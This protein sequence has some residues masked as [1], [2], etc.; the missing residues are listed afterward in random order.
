GSMRQ[1]SGATLLLVFVSF[2]APA[3][4]L[5]SGLAKSKFVGGLSKPTAMAFAPDGRIFV[6][7]RGTPTSGTAKIRIIKN[8]SLLSTP[9]A[10]FSVDNTDL[11]TQPN[12]RGLVGLALDPNFSDPNNAW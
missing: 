2:S 4:A 11:G 6:T 5:P 1:L 7:E 12:E 9:F 10:S 8:G 3:W